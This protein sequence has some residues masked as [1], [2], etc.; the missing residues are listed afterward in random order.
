MLIQLIWKSLYSQKLV[1]M[2]IFQVG[3]KIKNV[4]NH[5]HLDCIANHSLKGLSLFDYAH[6]FH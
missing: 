2:G 1:K 5:H 6:G 4:W 3:V